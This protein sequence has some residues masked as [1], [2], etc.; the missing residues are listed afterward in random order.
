MRGVGCAVCV[1]VCSERGGVCSVCVCVCSGRGGVCSERGGVWKK[2]EWK[3]REIG[4]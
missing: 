3:V 1:C 4:K 2:G